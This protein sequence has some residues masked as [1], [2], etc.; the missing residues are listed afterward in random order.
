M[1]TVPGTMVPLPLIVASWQQVW[2]GVGLA[3]G[4]GLGVPLKWHHIIL[5][6]STRQPSL[7][8]LLSLAIRHRRTAPPSSDGRFTTVVRKPPE[9][10][11]HA[12]R[13]AIGLPV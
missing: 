1:S 2:K 12:W 11:L 4:V 10:P 3:V 6:V 13:P 7:A 8:P 5:V 9:L